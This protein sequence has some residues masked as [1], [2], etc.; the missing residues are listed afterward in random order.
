VPTARG[1]RARHRC[2]RQTLPRRRPRVG[3]Q[4]GLLWRQVRSAHVRSR[5]WV[6]RRRENSPANWGRRQGGGVSE[7]KPRNGGEFG[8]RIDSRGRLGHGDGALGRCRS[9]KVVQY[10]P[11]T[12][13][14]GG[15]GP[16]KDQHETT[17]CTTPLNL[18][19]LH[20][21]FKSGRRLQFPAEIQSFVRSRHIPPRLNCLE[22]RSADGD[23][24]AQV[25]GSLRP[26]KSTTARGRGFKNLR[27][28]STTQLNIQ[29]Q[30]A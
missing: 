27:R 8:P 15:A 1:H 3:L 16:T 21:R 9:P 2:E 10:G 11:N 5:P 12:R 14:I 28:R 20:P 24:S 19:N 30:A 18:Q 23:L 13:Q 6:R 25:A 17:R 26:V 22:F 4:Q 7:V 29:R